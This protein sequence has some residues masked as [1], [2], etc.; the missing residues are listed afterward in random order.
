LNNRFVHVCKN[1]S[2]ET[3]EYASHVKIPKSLKPQG[4]LESL[5]VEVKYSD[6]FVK[7]VNMAIKLLKKEYKRLGCE[8]GVIIGSSKEGDKNTFVF[9]AICDQ[10]K[11]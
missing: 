5:S 3:G 4:R 2:K 9:T 1:C 8:G 10:W 11:D 7:D 6:N